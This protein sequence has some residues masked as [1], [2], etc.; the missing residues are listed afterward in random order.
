LIEHDFVTR[1]RLTLTYF[2]LGE[3]DIGVYVCN[4]SHGE[5]K[6]VTVSGMY[7]TSVLFCHLI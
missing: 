1:S 3:D 2:V 5:S 4:N 7:M 6:E